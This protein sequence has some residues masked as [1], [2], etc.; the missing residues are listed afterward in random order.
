MTIA[1]KKLALPSSDRDSGIMECPG[2]HIEYGVL[3]EVFKWFAS[4]PFDGYIL[5]ESSTSVWM[6]IICYRSWLPVA[7]SGLPTEELGKAV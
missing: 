6:P 3:C 7:Q 1:N 4:S 5:R 2:P